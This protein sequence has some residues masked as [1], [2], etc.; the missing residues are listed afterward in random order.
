LLAEIAPD[1]W[2]DSVGTDTATQCVRSG[3]SLARGHDGP[4][5]QWQRRASQSAC[6]CTV[7]RA[8]RACWAVIAQLEFNKFEVHRAPSTLRAWLTPKDADSDLRKQQKTD[9]LSFLVAASS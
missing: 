1:S 9:M 6:R 3:P 4:Y 5:T 2:S 8:A 7:A